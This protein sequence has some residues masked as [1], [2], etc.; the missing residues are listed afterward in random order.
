MRILVPSLLA[1]LIAVPSL[2]AADEPPGQTARMAPCVASTQPHCGGPLMAAAARHA[3]V[4]GASRESRVSA[5]RQEGRE[6]SW[7]ARH[8]ALF[9]ALI[10]AGGGVVASGAM[11]NEL[12]CSGSDE[13]CF[14]HGASRLAVGA[15]IGA[16]VGAL[17][18]LVVGVAR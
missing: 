7:P 15:G 5:S 10:G 17:V 13:D 3:A 12:F 2:A 9:G 16:G 6:R 18:G 4:L 1:F 11:N 8:P 14:F